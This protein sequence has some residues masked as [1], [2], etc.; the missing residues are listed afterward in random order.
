M[1]VSA[2][3]KALENIDPRP[4]PERDLIK[5]PMRV[6]A[7]VVA[8]GLRACDEWDTAMNDCDIVRR[9][10]AERDLSVI[11]DILREAGVEVEG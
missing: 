10:R 1:N 11:A 4:L 3:R 9:E 7:S 6:L 2:I 8:V 5:G